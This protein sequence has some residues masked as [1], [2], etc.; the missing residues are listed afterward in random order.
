MELGATHA[1]ATVPEAAMLVFELTR[2]NMAHSFIITTDVAE[3]VVTDTPAAPVAKK[4]AG[5]GRK[6]A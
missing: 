4:P 1:V 5:K 2:G 6:A 3:G